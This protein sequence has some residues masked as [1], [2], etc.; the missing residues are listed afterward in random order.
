MEIE[1]ALRDRRSIRQYID[2]SVPE[3]TIHEILDEAHWAP[4]WANTQGWNVYVVTG[5]SLAGIKDAWRAKMEAQEE[6]SFDIPRPHADWPPELAARTRQLM[7]AR[8][9]I[10]PPLGAGT[11]DLFGA[12]CLLL[13]A[14]DARLQPEYA[15][16]DTGML[17][18]S[19][20]LDAHAKGL[21]TCI[22]AMAV[23][24]PEVLRQFIPVAK[25]KR[26][27]IGVALGYPDVEAPTNRF[28]RSRAPLAEI[29]SWVK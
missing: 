2:K 18:Q 5:A 20:C 7:D 4:S 1:S 28:E 12:P 29:V 8:A 13:F 6:R 25:G 24:Y 17:V 22:M 14:I 9:A 16:F 21:G 11:A 15:C 10:T 3:N 26:F 27:V 19:V 23:G